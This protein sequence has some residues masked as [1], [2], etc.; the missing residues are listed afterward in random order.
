M[1]I[2]LHYGM[3]FVGTNY[4]LVIDKKSIDLGGAEDEARKKAK[5]ILKEKGIN[6]DISKMPF[7]WN[8]TM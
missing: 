2:S 6:I 3:G 7:K 8:G 5:E 1:E 4:F